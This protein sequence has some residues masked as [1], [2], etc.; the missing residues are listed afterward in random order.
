MLTQDLPF[1]DEVFV[2]MTL[3]ARSTVYESV[4]LRNLSVI[5]LVKQTLHCMLNI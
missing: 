1:P 3:S 5:Y 2:N 4:C